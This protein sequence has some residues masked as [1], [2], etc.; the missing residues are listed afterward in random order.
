MKLHPL[1]KPVN[2]RVTR[3]EL[4][5]ANKIIKKLELKFSEY[6]EK[7]LHDANNHYEEKL[8]CSK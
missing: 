5:R 1:K 6:F 7:I 2:V 8:K 3:Y 4:K